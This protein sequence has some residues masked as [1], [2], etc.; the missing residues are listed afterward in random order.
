[1]DKMHELIMHLG[2]YKDGEFIS[3]FDL[4]TYPREHTVIKEMVKSLNMLLDVEFVG[5]TFSVLWV[6]DGREVPSDLAHSD[7]T[8]QSVS[9]MLP[10]LKK[11]DNYA[12]SQF[13][14]RK[15]DLD[16]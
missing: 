1:M 2:F 8:I 13:I 4:R 16:E 7:F 9:T 14:F 5:K 12:A 3:I 10:H 6:L 11:S 15:S